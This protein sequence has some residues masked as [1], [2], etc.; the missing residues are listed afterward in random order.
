[1]KRGGNVVSFTS[2]IARDFD[3]LGDK[4]CL[5]LSSTLVELAKIGR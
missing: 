4:L 3:N 5:S 1:M 2:I